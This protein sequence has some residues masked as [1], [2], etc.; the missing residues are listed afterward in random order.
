MRCAVNEC[1]KTARTR[2]WCPAHYAMWVRHGDPTIRK[3]RVWGTGGFDLNGYK[4]ITVNGKSI[5][6]HRHIMTGVLGR[7][8]DR[9]E[10][11]HHINGDRADNRPENLT[12]LP[13]WEHPKHH[14]RFR[15]ETHKQ[16]C[17]CHEIKP[18]SEFDR[19][20]YANETNHR[21]TQQSECRTC[22]RRRS[23]EYS[24]RK[25]IS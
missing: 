16:C 15:N 18:R 11:V 24:R 23:R 6:E 12:V 3:N 7:A 10:V 21:D 13:R 17:T 2:G 5:R 19:N 1:L 22:G 25:R 14:A 4:V 9:S 8:L 20:C